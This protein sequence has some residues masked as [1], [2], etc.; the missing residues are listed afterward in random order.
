MHFFEVGGAI[1]QQLKKVPG[2]RIEIIWIDAQEKAPGTR[3]KDAAI[4]N[5]FKV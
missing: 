1:V 4:V 3:R 5:V 2:L